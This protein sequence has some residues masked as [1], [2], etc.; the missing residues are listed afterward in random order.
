MTAFAAVAQAGDTKTEAKDTKEA[1][2]CS[3][4]KTEQTSLERVKAEPAKAEAKAE[5]SCCGGCCSKNTAKKTV[6]RQP[7]FSPKSAELARR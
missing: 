7:L 3:K 5:S 1:G 2:C 6:V 4:P